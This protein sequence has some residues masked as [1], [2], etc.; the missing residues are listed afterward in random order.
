MNRWGLRCEGVPGIVTRDPGFSPEGMWLETFDVDAHDG[1]GECTWTS[2]PER[3]YAFATPAE[4]VS[5]WTS[6]SLV[7]PVRED[8]KPN[9]PLT[10]FTVSC[11]RLP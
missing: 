2:K 5:A 1:R 7:R 4:A 11:E 8:G 9:R 10:C 3:A 6:Q